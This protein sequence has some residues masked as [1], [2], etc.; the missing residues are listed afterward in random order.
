MQPDHPVPRECLCGTDAAES[1]GGLGCI[2][3]GCLQDL[4]SFNAASILTAHLADSRG[5]VGWCSPSLRFWDRC[6]TS[7]PPLFAFGWIC[8]RFGHKLALC[9]RH[10]RELKCSCTL[11][12]QTFLLHLFLA[13]EDL[14]AVLVILMCRCCPRESR[15]RS[16]LRRVALACR[17][18]P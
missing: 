8:R 6:S 12:Q 18:P 1:P 16:F 14:L 9:H 2:V 13:P 15:H 3:D 5:D 10:G 7:I 17:L 11:S 4:Q